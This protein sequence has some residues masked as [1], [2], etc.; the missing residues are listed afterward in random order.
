MRVVMMPFSS[1][2]R[3]FVPSAM[4]TLPSTPTAIPENNFK[5]IIKKHD[6]K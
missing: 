1:T 5:I 6:E 4:N 3:M 2:C